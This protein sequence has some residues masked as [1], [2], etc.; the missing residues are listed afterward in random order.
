QGLV[1]QHGGNLVSGSLDALVRHLIPTP[2]YYPERTYIFA[3]LLSS[4]LF[5][6]P[7][8]LL[9][10]VCK[11]CLLQQPERL[12]EKYREKVCPNVIRLLS[13]WAE[14]FPYDFRDERMMTHVQKIAQSDC[15]TKSDVRRKEVSLVLH[16][17]LHKLS[18][19]EKYEE[20][21]HKINTELKPRTFDQVPTADMTV[22]CPNSVNLA[23]QLTRIELERLSY[24]GPEEFVQA[25]AKEA[26][27]LETSF[28]DMK[29]TKNLESYIQWFNRLSFFVA[30]EIVLNTKKK[31]RMK[32]IEYWIEVARECFNIGNFNSLMAIIAG[33]NMSPVARLKKTWSKVPTS[34]LSVLE[35]QMSPSSNF[36]SYRSTLA[37]AQWRSQTQSSNPI[38]DGL[39][40]IRRVGPFPAS[41]S[42]STSSASSHSSAGSPHV[43]P[44][45]RPDEEGRRRIIIPFFSLLVKDLYF[46]NEGCA[47]RSPN[48][49]INF[50]KF[51]QLAKQI[52]EFMT[53]QQVNC[54]FQADPDVLTYLQTNPVYTEEMLAVASF[55][56]EPPD[57]NYEKER[58]KALKARYQ[59]YLAGKLLESRS[60]GQL[61]GILSSKKFCRIL[62]C[63]SRFTR[64]F[65]G[66]TAR[67][68]IKWFSWWDFETEV[69]NSALEFDDAHGFPMV[70]PNFVGFCA[71][72][73]GS[74]GNLVGKLL[75]SRPNGS[76]SGIFSAKFA[77]K[78][79]G[80][81]ARVAIK[82][83]ARR[84]F[85]LQVSNSSLELD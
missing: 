32:M 54:P 27:N 34:K 23:K 73:P 21:L 5:I 76:L 11:M 83:P 51:W 55:E 7:H 14:L 74:Q 58:H 16:N 9:G 2:D 1:Y 6:K 20:F 37:A 56:C 84:D 19:L 3:F 36:T 29:K 81:T 62:C 39:G 13:E 28:K 10:E 52:T 85:E 22:I 45:L 30:T 66:E 65:G 41:S 57:N 68:A 80:E 17:L 82:W 78:F 33:L 72:F 44:N 70:K 48:G 40:H 42:S 75:E 38:V 50:E 69:E 67:V 18:A 43:T 4:R 12:D 35:Q 46:L 24:I 77:G 8:I 49:L 64:K 31:T 26:P 59:G 61:G 53:W 71:G 25:F 47:S 63:F 15:V 60:N 79:C